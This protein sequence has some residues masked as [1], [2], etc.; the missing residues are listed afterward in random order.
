MR[1]RSLKWR[2]I[3]RL[4][5]LQAATCL[6]LGIL[7]VFGLWG[8]GF[9]GLSAPDEDSIA[10][11]AASVAWQ[12]NGTMRLLQSADLE[13]ERKQAP[14]FWALVRDRDGR[15][16][17]EGPVPAPFLEIG[18][19]GS[20]VAEARF[21]SDISDPAAM[22][23]RLKTVASPH[24]PLTIIVG[25]QG[26]LP[27]AKLLLTLAAFA[28]GAVIPA[29]VLTGLITLAV[30]PFVARGVHRSLEAVARAA[31]RINAE[32][33]GYRLP[34][35]TVPSEI[36]PLV[37]S[38][39]DTLA[40]LDD[41]YHRQKRFMLAA[42]HELR[43]PIAIL[44]A[45][46]ATMEKTAATERLA[47]DISRLATLAEQLLDLQRLNSNARESHIVDLGALVRRQ[48]IELAPLIIAAGYTAD[49]QMPSSPLPIV[50]DAASIERA[51][52]NL[53]QNAVQHGGRSG[54]ITILVKHPADISISD[55]GDGIPQADR[56]R[57][58][59]PFQRIGS[60]TEGVGLGLHLVKD[61]VEFHG[62]RIW[63]GDASG[64]GASF[65]IAF[66]PAASDT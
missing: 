43:T 12:E 8:S 41:A 3:R 20:I 50:G 21:N 10:V 27:P 31:E 15:T 17:R 51:V 16:L 2:L 6:S 39:N 14:G 37:L 62:G 57:I 9:T 58:F 22:A 54:T 11:V 60:P 59:E 36:A 48:A 61:I 23:A 52:A 38:V 25:R 24:G 7:F 53:V 47:E 5:L 46:L 45:R 40:R 56:E 55:E 18:A 4:F 32:D 28:S 26:I 35:E 29:I 30:T 66:P 13:R 44:Q 34:L 64:G 1:F 63:V 49:F 65:N 33:R 42:A 19:L